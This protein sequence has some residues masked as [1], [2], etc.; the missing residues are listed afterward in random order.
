MK[1]NVIKNILGTKKGKDSDMDGVPDKKD[2][3]PHNPMRQD[4]LMNQYFPKL[5][6]NVNN[7]KGIESMSDPNIIIQKMERKE[8]MM[9]DQQKI[10]K[11]KSGYIGK[12]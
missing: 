1:H 4:I 6:S 7:I 2:C 8:K 5:V 12:I 3:Q 9:R 11:F 10:N